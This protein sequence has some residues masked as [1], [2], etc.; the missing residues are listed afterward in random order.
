[1]PSGVEHM[2]GYASVIPLV[3][4]PISASMPSGVEHNVE[5]AHDDPAINPISASMP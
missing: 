1:M 3:A 4:P 5:L 2:E